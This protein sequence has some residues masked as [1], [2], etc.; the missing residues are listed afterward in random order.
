MTRHILKFN[1][2]I[3]KQKVTFFFTER[4]LWW[5]AVACYNIGIVGNTQFED[6]HESNI[7]NSV[8]VL[9]GVTRKRTP[10]ASVQTASVCSIV[11]IIFDEVFCAR[12]TATLFVGISLYFLCIINETSWPFSPLNTTTVYGRTA[13]SLGGANGVMMLVVQWNE[14][15]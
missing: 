2:G 9:S 7:Q 14:F 15:E 11:K 10:R 13:R 4:T 8:F 3:V 1:Y 6:E 5:V 12:R